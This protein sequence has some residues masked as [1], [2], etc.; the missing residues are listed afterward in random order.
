MRKPLLFTL[1]LLFAL[2]IQLRGQSNALNFDGTD[3]FVLTSFFGPSGNQAR[4][5][6][7][8]IRTNANSDPNN[9]GLQKVIVDWGSMAT[10]A[11]F[12]FNL[13]FSN[14]IRIEVQGSGLNS[15]TPLN[16]GFWHHVAA[17]YDPSLTTD[18]FKLYVDGV[19]D[20]AGNLPTPVNTSINNPL[21]IGRR[22]DGLNHFQG[23]IDEVRCWNI[24]LSATAILNSYNKEFCNLPTGLVAYYKMN[25]GIAGGNNTSTTT[26]FEEINNNNG[27]L[28]NFGLIG[29]TSNWVVGTVT[30]PTTADTLQL[31]ACGSYTS[32][33]GVTLTSSGVIV[34]TLVG[35]N[36]CDSLFRQVVTI[37]QVN[38]NVLVQQF[39]LISQATGATAYQW[40]NCDG[41]FAAI[42][43][44][45][46]ATFL[47]NSNGRYAVIVTEGGCTDTSDCYIVSGLQT[48]LFDGV[49][50]LQIAPNPTNEFLEITAPQWLG[51]AQW[52]IT[53]MTGQR[54]AAGTW[55][56]SD[57]Q[58]IL[59]ENLPTGQYLFTLQSG[60]NSLQQ[61]RFLKN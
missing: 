59:V 11:R 32:P 60:S 1:S 23:D 52:W 7:A 27:V 39:T 9:G 41:G 20:T 4:T 24:A 8:W 47:P 38:T 3:D 43:G 49:L 13:L 31:T 16:D 30:A 33:S 53:D 58:K 14:A 2:N 29:S 61:A 5:V 22:L 55:L 40:V 10:G 17:V 28:Q 26:V 34:D 50:S 12:T 42:S 51:R 6:E 25:S 48:S 54:V 36:G 44:A 35:G 15:T 37:N 45:T 57:S 18:R 46:Q 19:L 21:R 56:N